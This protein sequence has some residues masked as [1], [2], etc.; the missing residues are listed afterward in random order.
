[1]VCGA[2]C[3]LVKPRLR[4]AIAFSSL[5]E[6]PEKRCKDC[7]QGVRSWY[8]VETVLKLDVRTMPGGA[9]TLAE[10][11][12]GS[13]AA[14]EETLPCEACGRDTKHERQ[15]RLMTVPNVLVVQM[16]RSPG[17]QHP[18]AVEE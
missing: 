3:S 10:L 6:K 1:M 2:V 5:S 9:L 12:L 13:C 17:A 14:D 8:A 4:T 15:S 16:K 11:Y 7:R 18:V